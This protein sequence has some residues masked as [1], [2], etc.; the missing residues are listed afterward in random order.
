MA[1]N[2]L[3]ENTKIH[4]FHY[5]PAA[6]NKLKSKSGSM[7][8]TMAC[9]NQPALLMTDELGTQYFAHELKCCAMHPEQALELNTPI[10]RHAN[11]IIA[12]KLY[13]LGWQVEAEQLGWADDLPV[14]ISAVIA[15]KGCAKVAVGVLWSEVPREELE[16][17]QQAYKDDGIRG[18]WLMRGR[19]GLWDNLNVLI[20]DYHKRT[21]EL[22]VF[23]LLTDSSESIQVTNVLTSSQESECRKEIV[24]GLGVFIDKLMTKSITFES[25][26][27]DGKN[28]L[29]VSVIKSE[30]WKCRTN[31]NSVA[32][33]RYHQKTS[34]GYK[35]ISEKT[36]RELR[37]SEIDMINENLSSVM[38]FN[39][40][41]MMF[42]KTEQVEYMANSCSNCGALMGKFFEED[43]YWDALIAH[44][45]TLSGMI[46]SSLPYEQRR[47]SGRWVLHINDNEEVPYIFFDDYQN[48]CL[49]REELEDEHTDDCDDIDEDGG[50]IDVSQYWKQGFY[51]NELHWLSEQNSDNSEWLSAIENAE[52]AALERGD[53]KP[54]D[55]HKILIEVLGRDPKDFYL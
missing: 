50:F 14:W 29:S 6:W 17:R 26:G 15:S 28:Y 3:H 49:D 24:L 27:D 51:E 53:N 8:L 44:Q 43:L 47:A 5:S 46:E 22:P 48:E 42:S 41:K 13:E 52:K 1:F 30:C 9:C 40:L 54:V 11:F 34:D 45:V 38:A 10:Q 4:S 39:P 19:T 12:G 35:R 2:C 31:I 20:G 36:I 37:H 16:R 25:S 7:I 33:V 55:V 32:N 23:S 21:N 18:V